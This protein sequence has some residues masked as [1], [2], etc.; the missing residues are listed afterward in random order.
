MNVGGS[1]I[2]QAAMEATGVTRQR[3]STM[4]RE[5]G[6]LGDVVQACRHN[7]VN[8]PYVPASICSIVPFCTLT[9]S[10]SSSK[11]VQL[12][13][14]TSSDSRGVHMGPRFTGTS[15][16]YVQLDMKASSPQ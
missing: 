2:S 5:L 16:L 8:P 6:D 12:I 11:I 13:W 9:Y 15:E 4:Y 1:V 14:H 3:L 7:Q 10:V